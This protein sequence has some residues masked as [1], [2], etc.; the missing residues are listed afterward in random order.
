MV[1]SSGDVV[2]PSLLTVG[3]SGYVTT[4]TMANGA[5]RN[6]LSSEL[7]IELID[8][9]GHAATDGTRALILRAEPGA[10]T[11]SAGHDITELPSDGTDPLT[12]TNPLEEFFRVVR[13]SPFPV[14]VA[15][16]G[17]VWGGACDLVL[18]CDLVVALRTATFAITPAKLGV[19][20]NTAGVA[21][22]V[23]SLPLNLAK[24]MFFTA[25]PMTAEQMSHHGVINRL[26]ADERELSVEANAL[27][28]RIASL[29]PLA[30]TAIKAEMVAL[31]DAS[32]MTSE[33]FERLTS[34]R[35]TAWRS[36]DYQEGVLAFKERRTANFSG[37]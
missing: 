13:A 25:N 31:T 24:E 1:T 37:N 32:P 14:I 21:H 9:F 20:Y 15:V 11:W 29:A 28:E 8:A 12:W 17:G 18:T 7:L 30:I 6:A 19:P 27:A 34:N 4:I 5:R 3:Q 2:G 35:R 26:V 23:S 22:F 16:E 33:T 10:S 36:N